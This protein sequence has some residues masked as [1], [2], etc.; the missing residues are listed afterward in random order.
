MFAQTTLLT[1]TAVM[2]KPTVASFQLLREV[3]LLGEGHLL[4]TA[5]LSHLSGKDIEVQRDHE[6]VGDT[7]LLHIFTVGPRLWGPLWALLLPSLEK[8]C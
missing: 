4:L 2:V 1:A 6:K 5:A 3:A 7:D 8:L